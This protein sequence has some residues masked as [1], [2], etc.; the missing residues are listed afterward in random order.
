MAMKSSGK[1]DGI[2]N[3]INITPLTDIFLVL[4]IIMMVIAPM[5]QAIDQDIA[6][7][8]INSGLHVDEKEVTVAITKD[9]KF[10]VNSAP[11]QDA[12]LSD[13]LRELLDEAKDKKIVVKADAKTK[14]KEIMK[15]MRSAQEAGYEKLTVAGEPLSGDQQK[16]LE[17][18]ENQK[19]INEES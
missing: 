6:L 15:V 3:E 11:I 14:T 12:Q 5:F 13:K 2:F 7:P 4:L 18:T 9:A 16:E 8:S 17:K 10:Y 19:I 1:N